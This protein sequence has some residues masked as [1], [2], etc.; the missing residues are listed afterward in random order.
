MMNKKTTYKAAKKAPAP[1]AKKPA[2]T[3]TSMKMKKK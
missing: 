1:K 3:K 2:M